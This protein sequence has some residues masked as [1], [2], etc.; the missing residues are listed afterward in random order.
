[1]NQEELNQIIIDW[2]LKRIKAEEAMQR[3]HDGNNVRFVDGKWR[4]VSP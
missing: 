4:E 3:I 1:M 2:K